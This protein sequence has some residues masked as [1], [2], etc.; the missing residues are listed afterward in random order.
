LHQWR[1]SV[2][3]KIVNLGGIRWTAGTADAARDQDRAIL[4]SDADVGSAGDKHR[5]NW[6]ERAIILE[7]M[8]D[9]DGIGVRSR[10]RGAA[11]EERTTVRESGGAGRS[12]ERAGSGSGEH[13]DH[14]AA[15]ETHVKLICEFSARRADSAAR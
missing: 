4:E 5:S 3:S 10:G 1:S 9:R 8:R 12:G 7:K 11:S 14:K 15:R 6:F 13:G 2:G